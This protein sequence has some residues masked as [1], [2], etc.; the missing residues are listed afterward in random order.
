MSLTREEWLE[1]W[2]SVKF[3]EANL[4]LSSGMTSYMQIRIFNELHKVKRQ[5]QSVIG[6]ME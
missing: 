1:M 6:Q 2:K 4:Q 5:V 3:I